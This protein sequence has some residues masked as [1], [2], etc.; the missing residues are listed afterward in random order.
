MFFDWL[1][2]FVPAKDKV[3]PRAARVREGKRLMSRVEERNDFLS[4]SFANDK[5]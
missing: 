1:V 4:L 5:R 3:Y 2:A